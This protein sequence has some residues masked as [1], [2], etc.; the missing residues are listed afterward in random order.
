MITQ[1]SEEFK[2]VKANLYLEELYL[3]DEQERI[4]LEVVNGN[5]TINRE[6]I[7]NLSNKTRKG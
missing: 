3:T 6:L 7:L 4:V 2:R 1:N 5:E